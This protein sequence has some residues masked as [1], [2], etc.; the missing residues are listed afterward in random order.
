VSASPALRRSRA[1]GGVR[2]AEEHESAAAE[3]ERLTRLRDEA[4]K[5]SP[6]HRELNH[7]LIKVRRRERQLMALRMRPREA[8]RGQLAGA[9]NMVDLDFRRAKTGQVQR[10]A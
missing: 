6:A 2:W 3:V 8:S 5:G 1:I 10:G 4:D 7:Q 9:G